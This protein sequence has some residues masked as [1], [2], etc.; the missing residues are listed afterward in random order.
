MLRLSF[1]YRLNRFNFIFF[2]FFAARV[3][4]ADSNDSFALVSDI[5]ALSGGYTTS[6]IDGFL[7]DKVDSEDVYTKTESDSNY[8]GSVT[9]G[10]VSSIPAYDMNTGQPNQAS[11]VNTGTGNEAV[12]DFLIPQGIPGAVGAT[13][14]TGGTGSTGEKGDKGDKGDTGDAGAAGIVSGIALAAAVSS[15]VSSLSIP[16]AQDFTDLGDD[17]TT[18]TDD[19]VSKPDDWNAM[20][21]PTGLVPETE[22]NPY[23]L[24]SYVYNKVRN[25]NKIDKDTYLD[26][27]KVGDNTEV[28]LNAKT[29]KIFSDG[30]N[31]G[32]SAIPAGYK[33][34]VE[35]DTRIQNGTS[36]YFDGG[37]DKVGIRT[38]ADLIDLGCDVKIVGSTCIEGDLKV[39]GVLK[40]GNDDPYITQQDHDDDITTLTDIITDFQDAIQTN[41]DGTNTIPD[42]AKLAYQSELTPLQTTIDTLET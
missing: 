20:N 32:A 38:D 11:V 3:D 35:G 6:Q 8:L 40:N 16:T 4:V 18:L 14:G 1:G 41:S 29:T 33:L 19:K 23:S 13:G 9:I 5:P 15:H 30:V 39:S 25:Q 26:L 22:L 2:L 31:I 17:I 21:N 12:L 42:G 27:G 24:D 36:K 28:R 7:A 37:N 34:I 10:T